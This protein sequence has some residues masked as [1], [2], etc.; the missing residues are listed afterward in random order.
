MRW[1]E[2]FAVMRIPRAAA[3]LV[4]VALSACASGPTAD[5]RDPLEPFNRGIYQFNDKLDEVALKP[6]A[7]AYR[8]LVPERVRQGIGNFFGNLEDVWS[9]VNN[10]LQFKGQAALDS[11]RRVGVNTFLGWGGIFDVATEMDIEK[12]KRDFGHTLGY[13]GVAP[14]PYLVLP[15]LGASSLRDTLALPLDWKGDLVANLPAVPARNTAVGLRGIEERSSLLKASSMLEEAALDR[16]SFVRDA[17]LQRRRSVIFDGNPPE[18]EEEV[19]NPIEE[20]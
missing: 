1:R 11:V 6:V 5:P 13:W 2:R 3:L 20:R 7:Q 19:P 8:G 15:L 10:A 17:Y 18:L 16:Y 12:H 14:G 9:L 4:L